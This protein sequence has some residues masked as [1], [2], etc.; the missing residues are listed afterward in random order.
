MEK[1]GGQQEITIYDTTLRDG[2]QAEEIS[3]STED[4]ILIAKK[5]DELGIDYIEGGFPGSNKTDKTFFQEIKKHQLQ[6][7]KIAAFGSTHNAKYSVENDPNILA[8]LDAEPEIFTIFGKSWDLHVLKV[9]KISME[10]NLELIYNST[11]FLKKYADEVFYDA[12]HFFDGYKN[13]PEYALKT[14]KTAEE[15]GADCIILCDTNGGTITSEITEMLQKIKNEITVQLGIHAHNDSDVAVANSITAVENGITQVQ[16]TVNGYGERAGNANLCSVIPI[17]QIK[18]CFNCIS[19][20][21][22]KHLKET[23]RF[24]SEIANI[25]PWRH[26]PFVGESAAAHKGG[27]HGDAVLKDSSSYEHID[28]ELVGN[29]RRIL[30]S[31]LSGKA[32]IISKAEEYGIKLD[33]K[34]PVVSDVVKQLKNLAHSGYKFEGADGSFLLLLK[35]AMG[36]NGNFF[37]VKSFRIIIE[38]KEGEKDTTSEATVKIKLQNGG[39]KHAVAYGDGPVNALDN[40]LKKTLREHYEIVDKIH[41]TDFKVRIL[42][43][44]EGSQDKTRVLIESSDSTKTWGTVGVSENIIEASLNALVDGIK[45]KLIEEAEKAQK[46]QQI[47]A[48]KRWFFSTKDFFMKRVFIQRCIKLYAQNVQKIKFIKRGKITN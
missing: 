10:K 46:L 44:K 33:P 38:K 30:I 41:L 21:Q 1:P 28:P 32:N 40:V 23:S 47:K 27:V 4:K 31:G 12:E 29:N 19:L 22:L 42:G 6:H 7:A 25:K 24:V 48:Y 35:K 26:Q 15:A 3:F 20:E 11:V 14:I 8:L 43:E 2:S 36:V 16:C 45:Y 5:L 17:L 9:L 13:N 18:K 34:N 37:D 39:E